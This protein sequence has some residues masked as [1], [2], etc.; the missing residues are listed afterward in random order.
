MSTTTLAVTEQ[1]QAY[2]VNETL[3]EHPVLRELREETAQL[4]NSGL[5]I[6]A[7]QGQLMALLVEIVGARRTLDIGVFTGYSSLSVALALPD[8]GRVIACDV[9]EQWTAIARRYWERARVAH[10]VELR[11]AP[12]LETLDGLVRSGE[13][14][15]FDFAFIDADKGNYDAYYERSLTLLRRGGLIALDNTLWGGG[16][17]DPEQT[18]GDVVKIR[19]LNAKIRADERVSMSLVPIGDG[20]LLA[21]KR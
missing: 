10:K 2:L 12:A 18:S 17:A 11:L 15:A 21:R 3:R 19:A 6:A 16:V 8:D 7:E 5:Q 20:L 9:S 1:I 4:P 14:G 13:Q